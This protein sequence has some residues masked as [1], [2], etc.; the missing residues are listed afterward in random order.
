[1]S[2]ILPSSGFSPVQKVIV[3]MILGASLDDS[4]FF[5]V[6]TDWYSGAAS[7]FTEKSYVRYLYRDGRC[8]RTVPLEPNNLAEVY[9]ALGRISGKSTLA[10]ILSAYIFEAELWKSHVKGICYVTH[11]NPAGQDVLHN[12]REWLK[13]HPSTKTAIYTAGDRRRLSILSSGRRNINEH[14]DNLLVIMDELGHLN[15]D[16]AEVFESLF[17]TIVRSSNGRLIYVSTPG[18]LESKDDFFY[19]K[20][21]PTSPVE[22]QRLIMRIPTW[23]MNP[24]IPTDRF[25]QM[26][27]DIGSIGFRR[28]FGAEF[29]NSKGRPIITLED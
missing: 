19:Q 5:D 14:K 8:N 6:T 22:T 11:S 21:Y 3:K 1:M 28:E 15:K 7:K 12:L 4:R 17:P 9:L 20:I 25:R 26:F 16:S 13:N 23:E 10:Q 24:T 27:D 2:S 18:R 29:I